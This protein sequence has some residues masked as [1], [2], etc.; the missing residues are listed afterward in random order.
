MSIVTC[1]ECNCNVSNKAKTCPSCGAPIKRFRIFYWF[2]ISFFSFFVFSVVS[3]YIALQSN[4]YNNAS[5][6]EQIESFVEEPHKWDFRTSIDEVSGKSIKSAT[7]NSSNSV[8][9]DFPYNG[10]SI[11][12]IRVRNHPRFGKDIIFDVSKGQILC[13]S[14]NGCFVTVRFDDKP[15]KKNSGI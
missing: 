3:S 2:V 8:E 1:K 5:K 11:G 6:D 15:A 14:Y 7:L 12:S 4:Q 9:F 10:G 13:S